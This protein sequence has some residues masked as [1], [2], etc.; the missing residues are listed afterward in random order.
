M[1]ID[2]KHLSHEHED[3]LSCNT[4]FLSFANYSN[5]VGKMGSPLALCL[6]AQEALMVLKSQGGGWLEDV[7]KL[8]KE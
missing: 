4:D 6:L 8:P 1:L 7:L 5:S 2:R 3:L